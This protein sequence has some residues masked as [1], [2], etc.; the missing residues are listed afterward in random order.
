MRIFIYQILLSIIFIGYASILSS[1]E[2]IITDRPD[3]TESSVSIPKGALQIESGILWESLEDGLHINNFSHPTL[4]LRYGLFEI[5]ELRLVQEY[6]S[7]NI[8]TLSD[9]KIAEIRGFGDLQL[10]AKVEILNREDM[11]TQ[12]GFLSHLVI[13][14]AKDG[15]SN[16]TYS[17]IN[18]FLISHSLDFMDVGY[19]LGIDYTDS[20]NYQFAYTLAFVFALSEKLGFFIEPYGEINQD[21]DISSNLNS[22]FTYLLN[23]EMQVDLSAGKGLNH[24]MHFVSIGFSALVFP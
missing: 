18:R 16:G 10:G 8:K 3:Q 7:S 23:D 17:S 4:L 14:T 21:S 6:N 1:Q 24:Q 19:N 12:I 15:L 9:Q 5:L 20:E 22:G 13:P 2:K 11:I